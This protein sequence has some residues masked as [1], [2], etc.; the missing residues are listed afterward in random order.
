MHLLFATSIVPDGALASG[1]EIA[2]AAIIDALRRA[3]V[4]VTVVGFNWPGKP[5]ADPDNT[6]V[7]G[8]VDVR[9]ESAAPLQKLAWV[10][11]AMVSGLTFA[12]AKLRV[13]SDA[14]VRAAIGRAG[15][16]DGYVLNSVQFA[17]A[18]ETL[19]GDRP[20]IFV[21]HNVEHR[22]AEENAANARSLLQR[23]LFRREARLLKV[24][25][26]RLCRQARFVFTLAE[27][28]RAALGVASA[29][30][31]AV[32]P[33]VTRTLA[34]APAGS[35]RIDCD[36]ALIGTWTW[37]PN[38]I[39]LD[40][41]L[42]KVVPHLRPDF[43]IRIAGGMPSGIT[44]T[45]PGVEFVG[46]VPDAQDFVRAAAVIPLISTA[47]SGVQLKTIETFEL[48][49]PSVAT[50]RSLRGI[51]HRPDN[52]VVTDDP[53][54]FAAAL[55]AAAAKGRDVDGSAFHRRQVKALDAAI[56]LGLEKLG[57]VRQE[58]FA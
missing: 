8:A 50:S 29:D 19:F 30:R 47:G 49:L 20:S 40:W 26:E 53:I 45:H 14:E 9:T 58:A 43:R 4:R 42:Q 2:N 21:A 57:A 32:L 54:A 18:F 39:G 3:G 28:D 23:F 44:S 27:E 15:P 34:P 35:R 22:S 38:R 24:M 1:Y 31:S 41:F 12:S 37:Q 6:I 36:A 16:V 48:G 17:G 56:R 52:C 10:A 5:A 7:L 33:L 51:G 13:V 25:E 46:R 55:E 11:K